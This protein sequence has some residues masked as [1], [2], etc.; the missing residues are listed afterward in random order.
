MK[1]WYLFGLM[2]FSQMIFGQDFQA[3]FQKY[4]KENNIKKQAKI[5]TQWEKKN[6]KDAELFVSY[7]NYYFAKSKTENIVLSQEKPNSEGFVLT[8]D[9]Q[10]TAGYLGLD[11]SY[12]Q[13]D[14][15]K[16][17]AK[18]DKGIKLYPNR[19]DMRLGKIY[20]L[21]QIKD[22]ETFTNEIIKTI[23]Y[24]SQNKN[25]WDW[26]EN[27]N[28]PDAEETLLSSIQDYQIQLYN[29]ENDALLVNMRTIADA[30]LKYYP[31][32][33]RSY[34]NKAMSYII[35]GEYDKGLEVLL[36]AEKIAPNDE[37]VLSNIARVY[38]L[39]GEKQK[40]E[41]YRKKIKNIK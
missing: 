10:N 39:K 14:I 32:D 19:L 17:F 7:F 15:Q 26:T 25:H 20:V 22:W 21:G 24:S 23:E 36:K 35:L 38:E 16:G 8:D 41:I 33:I 34:N 18:I 1:K 30:V 9:K 5:L 3:D 31:N 12:N 4:F 27:K 29:T 6:P 2:V 28:L 13:E 11:T 40:E 37:I